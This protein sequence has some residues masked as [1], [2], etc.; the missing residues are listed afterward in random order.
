VTPGYGVVE[1]RLG[2]GFPAALPYP[3]DIVAPVQAVE[4]GV[5]FGN[6]SAGRFVS[7]ASKVTAIRKPKSVRWK[8]IIGF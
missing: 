2:W 3:D 6:T 8:A 7:D 5:Q 1:D 4:G